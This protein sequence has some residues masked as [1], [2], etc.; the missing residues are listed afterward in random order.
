MTDATTVPERLA[1]APASAKLVHAVL[2]D[3]DRPLAAAEL[4]ERAHLPK[5]TTHRALSVLEE[6]DV[7]DPT[8]ARDA[9]RTRYRLR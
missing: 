2:E 4:A 8:P 7:V 6:R 9:R 1:D 5:S 3:A